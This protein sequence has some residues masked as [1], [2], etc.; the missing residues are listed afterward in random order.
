MD[1]DIARHEILKFLAV[2]ACAAK[3]INYFI[4]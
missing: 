3:V 1:L 2:K 4:E